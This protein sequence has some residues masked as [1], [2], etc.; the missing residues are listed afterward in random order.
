MNHGH[1]PAARSSDVT[2]FTE[3][4]RCLKE[5][6]ARVQESGR[7]LY[8]TVNGATAAVVLSP[9]VYDDLL[10][11]AELLASLRSLQASFEDVRQG[12]V[13]DAG[14]AIRDIAEQLDLDLT[15]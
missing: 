8:V 13:Q 1:L 6:F 2:G 7:P 3:H 12:R 14:A 4:R 5:H 15:E 9:E 11:R 10:D